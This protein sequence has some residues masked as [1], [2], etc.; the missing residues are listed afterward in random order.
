MTPLAGTI[1]TATASAAVVGSG[2]TFT[3]DLV[4]GDVLGYTPTGLGWTPLGAIQIITDDTHLTL[5]ANATFAPAVTSLSGAKYSSV[6]KSRTVV[7]PKMWP[8]DS[9]DIVAPAWPGV[10][11]TNPNY[12]PND[13][14]I[15]GFPALAGTMATTT[16]SAIVT[17]SG[18]SFLT[19][20]APGDTIGTT[21]SSSGSWSKLG[22]VS[23]VDSA[24]QITLTAN[25]AAAATGKSYG[26]N[27]YADG[28]VNVYLCNLKG[29]TLQGVTYTNDEYVQKFGGTP[30]SCSDGTF[31]DG[32]TTPAFPLVRTDVIYGGQG[33]KDVNMASHPNVGVFKQRFQGRLAD[34]KAANAWTYTTGKNLDSLTLP[35]QILESGDKVNGGFKMNGYHPSE[36]KFPGESWTQRTR[37]FSHACAGCHNTGLTIDWDTVT[38]TLPFGRDGAPNSSPMSFSAIKSYRFLDEN[39]TCE[40]C[41]GPA[42]EHE[43]TGGGAGNHIINPKYLTAEAQRQV[44]GK[45]HAYDDATNAKP[46]QDYGFEFPWNSDNAAKIGGGDYVPG[47]Y[48][49]STYFDNWDERKVDDE[50]L[51]DPG[52]T[53]GRLYGQA[54]RQQFIMLSQSVHT[55]NPYKKTTCTS[56]HDNHSQFLGSTDVESRTNDKYRFSTADYRDNVLCLS[57]HA[58][59]GPLAIMP[60]TGS[61]A[62]IS[63]DDVANIHVLGGGTSTKNGVAIAP[64]GDEIYASQLAISDAVSQHMFA[65]A[66]MVALYNPLND[67]QPVGRCTSCHMPKLAKSGGYTTGV[68]ANGDKAIIEGDQASHYFD[69]VWPWQSNALSR[70]GPT[71]QSGYYGQLVSSTNVKY[72]LFGFMPNSCNKCH[73]NARRASR[74]CADTSTIWPSFWPFSGHR[75]DP[76]W[77][78]CYT[79]TTAP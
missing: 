62:G 49:L 69:I 75:T 36:Q 9:A 50:A 4:M 61:F 67:A 48:D 6:A 16:G 76:Y 25:V 51:W 32:V 10:K 15:Y 57:C 59:G 20:F 46:A 41:H 35:V 66:N 17:G 68:D 22:T 74:V 65:K 18:T 45:C 43:S 37:T 42:G 11:A 39:L 64:T 40:Q 13:P 73:V 27:G 19:D 72:D 31:W 14:R 79:S 8:I 7:S 24:T 12:D 70:G 30:Y 55:N 78:T 44:C 3:T 21:A 63:K 26:K 38:V 1:T 47:V 77:S 53:G 71:F 58:G 52:A 56:C 34:I 23:T 60:A 33:D 54:H 5:A 2:T 29:S 28:L